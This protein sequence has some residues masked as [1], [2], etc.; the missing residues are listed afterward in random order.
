MVHRLDNI[1]AV[2]KFCFL[3]IMTDIKIHNAQ[4]LINQNGECTGIPCKECIIDSHS[5]ILCILTNRDRVDYL[6]SFLFKVKFFS[7]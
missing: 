7:I 1:L 3:G 5:R 6:Q 2:I 4:K